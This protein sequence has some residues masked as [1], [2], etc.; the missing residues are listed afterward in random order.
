M[1][2]AIVVALIALAGTVAN[3]GLSYTF[4]T[5]AEAR[6]ELRRADAQW[7]RHLDSLAFAAEELANRIDNILGG[8]FLDA[9]AQGPHGREAVMSSLFRFAQ[10]FGWSEILRR[11][12]RD[13]D[14]RHV[15]RM[16]RIEGF[17]N[18]VKQAFSTDEYGAGGFMVW[19]EAQR[20][21]G[22]LMITRED[23]VLDTKGVAGFAS[24][25]ERFRP[26]MSR[27]EALMT[28]GQS[29]DWE[30]GERKRLSDV[31]ELLTALSAELKAA[32]R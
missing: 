21:V 11:Y 9:Y 28:T 16:E 29:S 22:E 4:N 7:A 17:Q 30:P 1:D 15:E 6:R 8:E 24:E 10:Y 14:P 32:R 12:M 2:A 31:R 18:A 19:R 25:F 23:D 27:M 3:A 13:P 20:A 26:W 5:R